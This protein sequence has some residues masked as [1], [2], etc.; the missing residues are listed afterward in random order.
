MDRRVP[1]RIFRRFAKSSRRAIAPTRLPGLAWSLERLCSS[2]GRPS[3]RPGRFEA[4]TPDAR[5]Y[6]ELHSREQRAAVLAS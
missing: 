1:V 2:A 3:H 6:K 5:V 4:C